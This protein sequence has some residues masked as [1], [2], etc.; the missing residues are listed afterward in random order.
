MK[1]EGPT[2][3]YVT[4]EQAANMMSKALS[5]WKIKY[6]YNRMPERAELNLEDPENGDVLEIRFYKD[7]IDQI[8]L[9][10]DDD[11][12]VYEAEG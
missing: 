3:K 11:I 10:T 2:Y 1:N 9:Y 6:H 7:K 12:I 8:A 5:H 4:Q